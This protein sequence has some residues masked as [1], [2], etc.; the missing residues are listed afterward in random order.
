MRSIRC[1][2]L[3]AALVVPFAAPVAGQAA[4]Q[5]LE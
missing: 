3:F 1:V 5:S 2:A 4:N